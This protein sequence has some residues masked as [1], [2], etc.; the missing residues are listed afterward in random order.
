MPLR[1][2]LIWGCL[3]CAMLSVLADMMKTTYTLGP[4]DEITVTVLKHPEL[5]A[6]YVI[7]PDGVIDF[8]RA[9]HHVLLGKTVFEVAGELTDKYG[10][11]LLHPEV[12][13]VLAKARA[14]TAFIMGAVNKP[15]EYPIT[16]TTHITQLIAAAGD[17]LGEQQELS[18]TLNR[19]KT[20]LPVDLQAVLRGTDAAA[21]QQI[22]DGDLLTIVAPRKISV[23]VLGMVKNPGQTKILPDGKPVDALAQ[24][25]DL[26]DRPER[27]RITLLHGAT[28]STL[29]WRDNTT[30]LHDGDVIMVEKETA[31]RVTV[32]GEV[33]NPGAY[34][35][36]ETGSV[37]DAI[38][39][40][41]GATAMAAM[42]IVTVRHPDNSTQRVDLSEAFSRGKIDPAMNPRLAPGDQVIVPLWDATFS[43]TGAVNKSDKY[44]LSETKPTTVMDA[45][46]LAGIDSKTAKWSDIVLIRQVKGKQVRYDLNMTKYLKH[47]KTNANI[48]LQTNDVVYVPTKGMTAGEVISALGSAGSFAYG[49]SLL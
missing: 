2:L 10:E 34:E 36:L 29:A 26:L 42:K 3:L 11:I 25:G 4:Q 47:G 37:M 32:S 15:G 20:L 46:S 8:P 30:G 39:M 48:E 19:G 16:D 41:G 23:T 1:I 31:V 7:P 18:A 21:N 9:G 49:I 13:V 14:H 44:P 12:T 22:Q 6:S 28:S 33:R 5:S 38:T 27:M 17:L 43:V 45:L 40:A 24:A 35:L